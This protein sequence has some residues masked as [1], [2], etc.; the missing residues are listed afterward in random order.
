MT[1]TANQE[2]LPNKPASWSHGYKLIRFSFDNDQDC[3]VVVNGQVTI[4][5]KAG[6]G[7]EIGEGDIPIT[8]F[9]IVQAGITFNWIGIW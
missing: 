1:S 9:K 2:L 7:F 3:S 5:L 6:Q 8:S 4:F